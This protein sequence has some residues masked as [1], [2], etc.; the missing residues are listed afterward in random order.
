MR[1]RI[2]RAWREPL[3]SFSV[4]AEYAQW[5]NFLCNSVLVDTDQKCFRSILIRLDGLEWAKKPS[6]A[7]VPLRTWTSKGH[8]YLK[9]MDITGTW[10]SQRTG[11]LMD[12]N[13]LRTWTSYGHEH[14]RDLDISGTWTSR[15]VDILWTGTSQKHEHFSDMDNSGT[16][17]PLAFF[18][19]N[20]ILSQNFMKLGT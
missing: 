8:E 11:R 4:L 6:H 20:I 16:L 7:T 17:T 15:E 19:P 2:K 18:G 14:L 13:I 5:Y 10:T 12:M 9:D 1:I 3:T